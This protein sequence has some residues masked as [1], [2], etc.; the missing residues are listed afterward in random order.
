[1]SYAVTLIINRSPNI[2]PHTAAE[3]SYNSESP[4]GPQITVSSPQTYHRLNGGLV[5]LH[6]SAS[7]IEEIKEILHK[8]PIVPG[9]AFAEQ[10]LLIILFANRWA[11]LAYIYNGFVSC[12]GSHKTLW[13]NGRV[14]NFHY[15]NPVKPWK[16]GI[17]D[18][19]RA[20]VVR[21][22]VMFHRL[23]EKM[24]ND[25]PKDLEILNDYVAPH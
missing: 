1:M 3:H 13:N 18:K 25:A 8:S 2:C 19:E 4:D 24:R 9:L 12:V 15:I 16:V 20:E 23:E 5:V 10:D 21:W 11:P 17:G 7:T 14:K 22:W 6:P